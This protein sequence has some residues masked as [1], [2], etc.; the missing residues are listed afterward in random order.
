MNTFFICYT[1][2]CFQNVPCITCYVCDIT[3]VRRKKKYFLDIEIFCLWLFC[4]FIV[5]LCCVVHRTRASWWMLW[6]MHLICWVSWGPPCFLQRATMS[7]VSFIVGGFTCLTLHKERY[8]AMQWYILAYFTFQTFFK[9]FS[10]TV[11]KASEYIRYDEQPGTGLKRLC[12][13]CQSCVFVYR[14]FKMG[15][16]CSLTVFYRYGHLWRTPLPRGLSDWRVCKGT[17]GGR[18]LRTGPICRQHN[19]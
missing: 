17:Q 10:W 8:E 16:H 5:W 6:S 1:Y 15:L 14:W 3:H 12:Q 18:S 13:S 9:N 2:Q 11:R 4:M 7:S 19:P